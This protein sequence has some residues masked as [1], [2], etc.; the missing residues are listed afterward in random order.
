MDFLPKELL[1]GSDVGDLF[2]DTGSNQPV[3]EPAI[4]AF[5]LPFGLWRQGIGDFHTTIL[6]DLFPLRSGLIGQ[7]IMLSPEGISSLD[8]SKDG[9]GVNIVTVRESIPKDDGLK[10]LDVGP[11]GLFLDQG[12]I[13]EEP[14]M[15]I[16]GSDEIPFLL[17][18]GCPEMK[19]GVMLNQF[20]NIT[21]QDFPVMGASFGFLEIKPMLSGTMNNRV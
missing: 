7:E 13:H 4:R 11:T 9:M 14:T 18:G 6:Q 8:K 2:S 20:S 5:H 15:I 17:G 16:Q 21:G 12:G 10:G 1:G 19:R 3:L